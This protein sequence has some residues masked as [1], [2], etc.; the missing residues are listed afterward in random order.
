MKQRHFDPFGSATQTLRAN[1][2]KTQRRE[3]INRF[4]MHSK[5][6]IDQGEASKLY[7]QILRELSVPSEIQL[8]QST[9]AYATLL[10]GWCVPERTSDCYLFR[11]FP[12]SSDAEVRSRVKLS[13]LA[14]EVFAPHYV[15]QPFL[16]P[17]KVWKIALLSAAFQPYSELQKFRHSLPSFWNILTALVEVG[18]VGLVYRNV[19]PENVAVDGE[20]RV[21]FLEFPEAAEG[22]ESD[23]LLL[24]LERWPRFEKSE[25]WLISFLY[26]LFF[27]PS[28]PEARL[29]RQLQ[30]EYT[31]EDAIRKGRF[32]KA[33]PRSFVADDCMME[34]RKL[35]YLSLKKSGVDVNEDASVWKNGL[36]AS[37]VR[38]HYASALNRAAP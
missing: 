4:R 17:N 26:R 16:T 20:G 38:E 30:V 32:T 1:P 36:F 6:Y 23:A 11:V 31:E 27:L 18:R 34:V 19:D 14:P 12:V 13:Q 7:E 2:S 25:S 10:R 24:L 37:C 9:G 15:Q 28:S 29:L 35:F 8:L 22:P 3:K 21:R 33:E 5:N